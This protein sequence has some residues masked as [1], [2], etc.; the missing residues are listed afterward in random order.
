[1]LSATPTRGPFFTGE[2]CSMW[3]KARRR[4]AITD[5]LGLQRQ[6]LCKAGYR[7]RH[8]E[9]MKKDDRVHIIDSIY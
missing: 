7:F 3:C 1:M 4:R 9:K 8:D 6:P 5:E 2:K